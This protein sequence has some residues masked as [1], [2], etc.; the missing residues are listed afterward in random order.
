MGV[1]IIPIF[2][3]GKQ[4]TERLAPNRVASKWWSRDPDP[5]SLAPKSLFSHQV[6]HP[7]GEEGGMQFGSAQRQ[8][9]ILQLSVGDTTCELTH[10]NAIRN[11]KSMIPLPGG[12]RPWSMMLGLVFLLII[13]FL[14]IPET[15]SELSWG[16][17]S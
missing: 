5:R 2:R 17:V 6:A 16:S 13:D 10:R 4:G 3:R 1:T 14:T 7:R 11:Y 15:T 12:P 9:E 8:G